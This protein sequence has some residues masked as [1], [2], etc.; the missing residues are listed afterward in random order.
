M[1]YN[2]LCLCLEIYA[3][4]GPWKKS[5]ASQKATRTKTCKIDGKGISYFSFNKQKQK[6]ALSGFWIQLL[7]IKVQWNKVYFLKY[8]G[9][10]AKM[11][12]F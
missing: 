7:I 4:E 9:C 6:K 3:Q 10:R 11:L 8:T 12:N 2:I 1:S 5:F